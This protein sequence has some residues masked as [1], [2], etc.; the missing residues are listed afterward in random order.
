MNSS[1]LKVLDGLNILIQKNPGLK[2]L[3]TEF[4]YHNSIVSFEDSSFMYKRIDKIVDDLKFEMFDAAK[5]DTNC[6]Q[7]YK[8]LRFSEYIKTSYHRS[9]YFDESLVDGVS[10][11]FLNELYLNI[12][13]SVIHTLIK[14]EKMFMTKKQTSAF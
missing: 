5:N 13:D 14:K 2:I 11:N 9:V 8:H 6:F 4:N 10:T 3:N 12:L 1:T 7:S